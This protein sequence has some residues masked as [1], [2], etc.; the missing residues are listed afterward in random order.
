M[1]HLVQSWLLSLVAIS[2]LTLLGW[3]FIHPGMDAF[4]GPK[5]FMVEVL[6]M[7]VVGLAAALLIMPLVLWRLVALSHRFVGPI[8]RLRRVMG[9][10]VEGGEPKPITFRRGDYWNELAEH[11]NALLQRFEEDRAADHAPKPSPDPSRPPTAT[12]LGLPA[13][14]LVQ[15]WPVGH[16]VEV[17]A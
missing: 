10:V 2:T 17:T 8:V 4:V 6:P 5:A 16:S 15:S 1:R 7:G 12:P 14:T 11:Y 3:M 9:E 13:S